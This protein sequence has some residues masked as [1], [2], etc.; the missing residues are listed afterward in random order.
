MGH[1]PIQANLCACSADSWNNLLLL[2][3]GVGSCM[4]YCVQLT[5]LAAPVQGGGDGRRPAAGHVAPAEGLP[6]GA[7]AECAHQGGGRRLS[8]VRG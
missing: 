2:C 7:D 4:L 8:E 6:E 1:W 3:F 5:A